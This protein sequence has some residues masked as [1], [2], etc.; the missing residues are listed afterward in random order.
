M[1]DTITVNE[2][3]QKLQEMG[4]EKWRE[5][6][7]VR[8]RNMKYGDIIADVDPFDIKFGGNSLDIYIDLEESNEDED[9]DWDDEDDED[10]DWGEDD[11]TNKSE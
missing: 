8:I 3:I 7:I 2:L 10:G 5:T 11:D 4:D 9:D 1:G 6:A